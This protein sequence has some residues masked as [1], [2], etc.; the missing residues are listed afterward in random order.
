MR[1]AAGAPRGA[2][3]AAWRSAGA[4]P[5]IPFSAVP[6]AP[7]I[8]PRG[9][10]AMSPTTAA[11]VAAAAALCGI[12]LYGFSD[13]H[14][15]PEAR[16]PWFFERTVLVESGG[17]VFAG[18]VWDRH[19]IVTVHHGVFNQTGVVV[20]D[21]RGRDVPA[22]LVYADPYSDV[23]VLSAQTGM[24][25]L[26]MSD[27]GP[28]DGVYAVGHPE[29]RP[30]AVTGGIISS[31]SRGAPITIQHDAATATGS[32]GGPLFDRMGRLV[33]MNA[34]GD[35]LS[36]AVPH[37]IISAVVDSVRQTGTYSPGCLG[38]RLDGDTVLTV[39]ERLAGAL[40]P[41]DVMVSVD[42]GVPRDL[43]YGRLPGD[44]VDVVL[45]DR[46]VLVQLG[47]METW[48]GIHACQDR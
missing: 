36:F 45:E 15:D 5:G 31:V 46:S 2:P 30:Y 37:W 13:A 35:D 41:G 22:V 34:A 38:V 40:H 14:T 32:S 4:A 39:R 18:V 47:V 44:V 7:F 8:P 33:G 29:G 17:R 27:A 21:A 11:A 23:A 3:P 43:L 16:I 24:G 25:P 6:G 42:G 9:N 28:G 26:E 10:A 19:T 12:L 20:T 1:P 48:F